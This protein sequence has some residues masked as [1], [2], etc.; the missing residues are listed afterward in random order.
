MQVLRPAPDLPSQQ[1]RHLRGAGAHIWVLTSPTGVL[2][3][4]LSLRT[5][6]FNNEAVYL[7]HTGGVW[8]R[9]NPSVVWSAFSHTP[10]LIPTTASSSVGFALGPV[11]LCDRRWLQAVI[12]IQ[13]PFPWP[14]GGRIVFQSR[15]N[16]FW[17]DWANLS[18]VLPRPKRTTNNYTSLPEWGAVQ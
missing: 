17:L 12:R 15:T 4:A 13:Y 11:P 16:L 7:P 14:M 1:L 3:Y 5:T 18:H 2:M 9:G 6:C 8:G 10:L